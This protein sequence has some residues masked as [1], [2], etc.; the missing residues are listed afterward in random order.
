MKY[1]DYFVFSS[2]FH[3]N[4]V[5]ANV[6]L[7]ALNFLFNILDLSIL[8]ILISISTNIVN[9]T[10]YTSIYFFIL[11]IMEIQSLKLSKTTSSN[12]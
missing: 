4:Y 10:I 11:Q 7:L 6:K 9:H 3:N 2:I 5:I 8:K 1:I 12:N